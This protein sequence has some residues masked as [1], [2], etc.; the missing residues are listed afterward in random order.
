MEIRLQWVC[1]VCGKPV[2]DGKGYL[3]VDQGAAVESYQ[4]R[5]ELD[6]AQFEKEA[7]DRAAGGLGLVPVDL[8]GYME[9]SHPNW[10][11]LHGD[12]DTA[13]PAYDYWFAVE[14]CRTLA[15]LLDWNAHLHGKNWLDRTDWDRFIWRKQCDR[16][17]EGA[18]SLGRQRRGL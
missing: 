9:L 15:Q 6:R 10:R 18:G 8:A 16:V 4:A 11:V 3:L 12:C 7:A 17:D 13:P 5:R 2:A 14:R 1:D